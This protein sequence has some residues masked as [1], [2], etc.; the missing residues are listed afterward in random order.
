MR[1]ELE[2]DKY[3][4]QLEE[5]RERRKRSFLARE[6]KI[7]DAKEANDAAALKKE[8]EAKEADE[9]KQRE[10][11]DKA[12]FEA[13]R[14]KAKKDE[15]EAKIAKAELDAAERQMAPTLPTPATPTTPVTFEAAMKHA[16]DQAQAQELVK[17]AEAHI[18]KEN[19]LPFQW[20]YDG[21]ANKD[22]FTLA[23]G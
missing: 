9:A 12:F 20:Q 6:Q 18:A 23:L 19:A 14:A 22:N 16:A 3:R 5:E 15:L 10:Q 7:Q 4:R 11:D 17:S 2:A 1:R 21:I 8:E 13:Q